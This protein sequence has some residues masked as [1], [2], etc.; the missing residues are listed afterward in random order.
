LT[1]MGKEKVARLQ[2]TLTPQSDLDLEVIANAARST[3]VAVI[4]DAI[5][6]LKQHIINCQGGYRR[7]Y[8]NPDN[9]NE[10][11]LIQSAY[12]QLKLPIDTD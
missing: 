7:E 9:P 5:Y 8:R 4:R 11:I 6:M 10:V 3:K 12:D 2:L 1:W